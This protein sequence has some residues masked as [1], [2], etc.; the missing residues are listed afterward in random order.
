MQ[1][2]GRV[3]SGFRFAGFLIVLVMALLTVAAV[4]LGKRKNIAGLSENDPEKDRAVAKKSA[5]EFVKIDDI[6]DDMVIDENGTRFTAAIECS[7][8]DFFAMDTGEQILVQNGFISVI[9]LFREDVCFLQV[10]ENVNLSYKIRQYG[11]ICEGLRQELNL[12]VGERN[13]YLSKA[14][15][16]T[17]AGEP[18]PDGL[19]SRLDELEDAIHVLDWRCAHVEDQKALA[20]LMSSSQ[21][22]VERMRKLILFSWRNDGGI[23]SEDLKGNALRQKASQE[24]AKKATQLI[25]RLQGARVNARRLTTVELVEQFRK[26][27]HP[28]T[29]GNGSVTELLSKSV[30]DDEAVTTDT[31]R[32]KIEDY[33]RDCAGDSVMG[34]AE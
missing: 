17:H 6:A 19:R 22:G 12:L 8:V 16:L 9:R 21:G 3:V 23:L 20:E 27:M 4:Y 1:E 33:T 31:Y 29:G 34:L 5:Y 2:I 7:G 30:S 18:V 26:Q 14:E 24:L 15:E 32:R 13:M 10:P 11:E 28:M 25:G